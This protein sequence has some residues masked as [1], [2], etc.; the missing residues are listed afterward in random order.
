MNQAQ[1]RIVKE[2]LDVKFKRAVG[3]CEEAAKEAA[4]RAERTAEIAVGRTGR[5]HVTAVEVLVSKLVAAVQAAERDGVRLQYRSSGGYHSL[6]DFDDEPVTAVIAAVSMDRRKTVR[7]TARRPF[8]AKIEKLNQLR[9]E[10]YLRLYDEKGSDL[11][12]LVNE[13]SRRIAEL[14]A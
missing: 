7:E 11:V 9:Q 2:T 8:E 12:A 1:I 13:V 10:T 3:E 14:G 5:T 6:S 4:D